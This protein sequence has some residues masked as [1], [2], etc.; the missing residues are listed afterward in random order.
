MCCGYDDA[1]G[2]SLTYRIRCYNLPTEVIVIFNTFVMQNLSDYI[3]HCSIDVI[4]WDEYNR[5][6]EQTPNGKIYLSKKSY[7][8]SIEN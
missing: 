1:V 4:Q 5:P 3:V 2:C 6:F 8:Y 7:D